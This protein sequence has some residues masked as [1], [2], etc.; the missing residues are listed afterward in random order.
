MHRAET[1][2]GDDRGRNSFTDNK[3][4]MRQ[5]EQ[6]HTFGHL[7]IK[8]LYICIHFFTICFE[9]KEIY[10]CFTTGSHAAFLNQQQADIRTGGLFCQ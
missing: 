2:R 10:C 3:V 5:K 7:V 6:Y 9:E 4:V 1:M 8:N